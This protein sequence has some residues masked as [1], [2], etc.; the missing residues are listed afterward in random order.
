MLRKLDEKVD[1]KF[2]CLIATNKETAFRGLDYRAP[3]HGILLLICQSFSHHREAQQAAYR[4]GRLNDHCY[5]RVLADISLI[6]TKKSLAYKAKLTMYVEQNEKR[7][8]IY[9]LQPSFRI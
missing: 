7:P 2:R 6:D 1:G 9:E 3:K 4:V 5:R 8:I